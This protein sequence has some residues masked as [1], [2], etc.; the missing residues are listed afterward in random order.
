ME[1]KETEDLKPYIPM[2][3]VLGKWIGTVVMYPLYA[4]L[5]AWIMTI[6]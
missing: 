6:I 3:T 5:V 1:I 4:L 2:K